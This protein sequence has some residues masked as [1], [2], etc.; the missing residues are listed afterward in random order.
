MLKFKI[1]TILKIL[2]YQINH[3]LISL[4]PIIKGL[5]QPC[6]NQFNHISIRLTNKISHNTTKIHIINLNP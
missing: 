6:Q 3:Q 2:T 5:S 1:T 4:I